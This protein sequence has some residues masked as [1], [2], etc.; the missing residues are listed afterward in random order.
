MEE[1]RVQTIDSRVSI[2]RPVLLFQSFNVNIHLLRYAEILENPQY[3]LIAIV[4]KLYNMIRNNE[5]S[6]YLEPE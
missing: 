1:N 2:T 6:E 5:S 3:S 4:Q